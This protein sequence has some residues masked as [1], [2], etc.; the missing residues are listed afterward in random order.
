MKYDIAWDV[1]ASAM[2]F[3]AKGVLATLEFTALSVAFGLVIGIA[4]V[5]AR[6]GSAAGLRWALSRS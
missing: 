4:G 2:P 1:I 6:I 5:A 3:L